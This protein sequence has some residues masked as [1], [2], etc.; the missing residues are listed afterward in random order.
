MILFMHFHMLETLLK[1]YELHKFFWHFKK[2]LYSLLLFH[3]FLRALSHVKFDLQM[4]FSTLSVIVV[5]MLNLL[6]NASLQE[7]KTQLFGILQILVY[8]LNK[9]K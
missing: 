8:Y 3:I 1:L 2:I 6:Y 5:C 4:A 9:L 7:F